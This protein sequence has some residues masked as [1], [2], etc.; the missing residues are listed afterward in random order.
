MDKH[1]ARLAAETASICEVYGIMYYAEG[2]QYS[3]TSRNRM[4]YSIILHD[5]RA[6]SITIARIDDVTVVRW[7][8]PP[9]LVAQTLEKYRSGG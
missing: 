4:Q 2:V 3:R 8:F 1:E 7:N 5:L 9:D 6:N